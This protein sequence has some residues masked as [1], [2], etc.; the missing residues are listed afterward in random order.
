MLINLPNPLCIMT[1]VESSALRFQGS[2]QQE[3]NVQYPAFFSFLQRKFES[4]FASSYTYRQW[5]VEK[6]NEIGMQ[7][8]ASI[9]SRDVLKRQLYAQIF[10]VPVFDMFHLADQRCQYWWEWSN[11]SSL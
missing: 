7:M 6:K 1:D 3:F 5:H 2:H 9:K 11:W 10:R 4:Q 8:L